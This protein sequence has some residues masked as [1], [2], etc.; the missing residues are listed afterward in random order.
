[1]VGYSRWHELKAGLVGL[2]HDELR[3]KNRYWFAEPMSFD[4]TVPML[5]LINQEFTRRGVAPGW[6]GVHR[7]VRFGPLPPKNPT[8]PGP[9]RLGETAKRNLLLRWI[10]LDWLRT[11]LGPEHKTKFRLWQNTFSDSQAL[12]IAAFAKV[13]RLQ[14]HSGRQRPFAAYEVLQDLAIPKFTRLGLGGLIDSDA[15]DRRRVAAKRLQSVYRPALEALLNRKV[16]PIT[17]EELE[18]RMVYCEAIEL[19]GGSPTLAAKAI[20]W[21]TGDD[22]TRQSVHEMKTKLAAQCGFSLRAWKPQRG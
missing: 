15:G 16:K 20:K 11:E 8:R 7:F 12:A 19:V 17:Q 3:E 22:V 14:S 4:F 10:D 5:W 9:Q 18:R 6:R 13:N 2:S 21:M 1:M